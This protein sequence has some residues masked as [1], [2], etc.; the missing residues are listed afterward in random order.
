MD[1]EREFATRA[2]H[3]KGHRS[4]LGAVTFPIFQ[5]ANYLYE[6]EEDYHQLRYIRLNNTPSHEQL[7]ETLASLEEGE[8]ALAAGSGMA[9]ITTALLTALKCGDH[10]LAQPV[11]YGGT[12]SFI[13]G[14]LPRYG[15]RYSFVDPQDPSQ[16]ES[17]M[18]P[19]TRAIYVESVANPLLDVID[20]EEV[21]AFARRHHLISIVDNTLPSPTNYNP[22]PHGFNVVVHSGTK[23]LNGHSDIVAG[24]IVGSEKFVRECKRTLDHLGGSLDPHACF[25]LARGMKTLALRMEAHNRN[26]LKV[27]EFLQAHPAVQMVRYP[28]LPS[29]P[30]YQRATLWFKGFGGIVTFELKGGVSA[31]DQFLAALKIPLIA[32]S[33]GGVESLITRP[34]LTSHAGVPPEERQAL[35]IS[36]PLIRMSVGV[37]DPGDLIQDMEQALSN[38]PMP[39]RERSHR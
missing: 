5:S 9:A 4:I 7:H 13:T 39:H 25:L 15:I 2:V 38:V 23:Y 29:D 35:G 33:L 20:L 36:D 30:S 31:A 21:I 14:D 32:P 8:A 24:A 27:A 6:G 11:L 28:G 12:R 22:L 19:E 16:W 37:E 3:G 17:L 26:A 34:T 18:T 1:H 10:L